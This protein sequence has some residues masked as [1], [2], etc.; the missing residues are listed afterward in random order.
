MQQD[1][2]NGQL[3]RAANEPLANRSMVD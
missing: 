2:K 1:F 3:K